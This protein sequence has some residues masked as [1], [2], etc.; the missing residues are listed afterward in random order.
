MLRECLYLRRIGFVY[1]LA[2]SDGDIAYCG[3]DP[4]GAVRLMNL[5]T[6]NVAGR[7]YHRR[8]HFLRLIHSA[9]AQN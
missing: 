3:D 4:K 6:R 5:F 7:A 8:Q 9:P 2:A 1:G